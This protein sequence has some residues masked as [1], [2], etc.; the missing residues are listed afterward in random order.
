MFTRRGWGGVGE[1]S[2]E[3]D[4]VCKIPP[5]PE[6]SRP[7]VEWDTCQGAVSRAFVLQLT[8]ETSPLPPSQ[9]QGISRMFISFTWR[10]EQI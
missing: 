8:E 3:E 4:A 10:S 5:L 1:R 9:C 2:K 7:G 6:P